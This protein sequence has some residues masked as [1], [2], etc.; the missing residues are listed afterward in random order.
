MREVPENTP[1]TITKQKVCN[2]AADF[3]A[4]GWLPATS[5][6][7]S[8]RIPETSDF[9][10]TRS[11]ADK[12]KLTVG[13]V[14]WLDASGKLREQTAYR[15]SA[16]TG[17]HQRLYAEAGCGAVVHV[18]TLHN[19]L[20]SQLGFQQGYVQLANHELLKALGHWDEDA[21][22]EVPIVE[23]FADLVTLGEAVGAAR[24]PDVPAVLV[25]NHGIYA[26]GDS[27]IAA[28]RHLEALEFL[29]EY[30]FFVRNL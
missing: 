7:I 18:H 13:D 24:K 6:N 23:N 17:V 22:I 11:G 12:Q 3:A 21:Q 14:L 4:K 25:R 1:I 28:K 16:E 2:L 9:C 8:V 27:D 29:F 20:M 10:V 15:P 19:N 30:M 5:G 26:W